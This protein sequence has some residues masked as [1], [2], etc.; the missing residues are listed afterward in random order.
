MAIKINRIAVKEIIKNIAD[1]EM[2]SISYYRKAPVCGDC[3]HNR[4]IKDVCPKCGSRNII[5]TCTTVAQKAVD[6]PANALKPGMGSYRGQSAENAEIKNNVLKYFNPN[7][8]DK[9]G[10]GVYR[11]CGYERIYRLKTKGV[12]F[13]VVDAV[14]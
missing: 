4:G 3:K 2:F 6:N 10:R 12:E 14:E 9:R 11:S 7:G 5:Y 1:G 13:E 8:M